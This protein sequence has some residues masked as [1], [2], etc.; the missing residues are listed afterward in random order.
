MSD[1]DIIQRI[2]ITADIGI[3]NAKVQMVT[4]GS[5]GSTNI[6]YD[7]ASFHILTDAHYV[8]SHV[9]ID[10]LK[11]VAMVDPDI[12]T[13]TA[14]LIGCLGNKTGTGSI[15]GSALRAGHIHAVI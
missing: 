6:A 4:G 11:A 7:L 9:H 14:S 1:F 10:G 2:Y 12:V 13:G 15:N 3:V 8:T 5:A